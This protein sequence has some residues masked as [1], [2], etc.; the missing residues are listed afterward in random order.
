VASDLVRIG[1]V[2]L[3]IL[4]LAVIVLPDSAEPGAIGAPA[5]LAPAVVTVLAA[6]VPGRR[7]PD[8]AVGIGRADR[9]PRPASAPL[10]MLG[11]VL[12]AIT[13]TV[14]TISAGVAHGAFATAVA[15]VVP[16]GLVISLERFLHGAKV[17]QSWAEARGLSWSAEGEA[18]ADTPLLRSGDYTYALNLCSG[19]LVPGLHGS[20]MH[21][22]SVEIDQSA[23]GSSSTTRRFTALVASVA[24]P[25]E[26]LPLCVCAPRSRIPGYDALDAVLKRVRRV[27]LESIEF[28]RRYELAIGK[29]GDESWLRRLFEPTF[30]ERLTLAGGGRL[31]WEVEA[32]TLTAYASGYAMS[33]AELDSL[34]EFAQMVSDRIRD[35][36]AETAATG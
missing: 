18:P 6:I 21:L 19:E 17:T 11:W 25:A 2:G 22:A 3:G 35:E 1:A 4:A 5:A 30:T 12:A 8:W 33:A 9:P 20:L 28:E 13:G 29:G 36:V 23:D 15:I 10:P 24:D 16:A 27:D 31:G 32:G 34:V 7:M 26:R 14:V